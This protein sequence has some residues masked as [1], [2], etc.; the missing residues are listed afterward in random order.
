M[1]RR[2][3]LASVA[4]VALAGCMEPGPDWGENND[5][6][7]N[8]PEMDSD[9]PTTVPEDVERIRPLMEDVAKAIHQYYP[10]ARI[11]ANKDA[12]LYMEYETDKETPSAVETELH[13]IADLYVEAVGDHDPV[14]FTIVTGRVQAVV[15]ANTAELYLN[16]DLEK[17][18]FHKTIGIASVER[19]ADQENT[20]Q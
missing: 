17:D 20:N 6:S 2:T 1:Q 12:E 7:Q 5:Q 14:T 4:S 3:L 8:Q 15:P 10:K 19:N 16:G 13:Q 9:R 18:A 11:F